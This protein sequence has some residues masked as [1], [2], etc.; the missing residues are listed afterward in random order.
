MLDYDDKLKKF[1]VEYTI[2]ESSPT[3]STAA[4]TAV[5]KQSGRLNLSFCDFDTDEKLQRRFKIAQNRRKTALL[6][7][8]EERII[9]NELVHIY[10]DLAMPSKIKMG[11]SRRVQTTID[12][13]KYP[14]PKYLQLLI[15]QAEALYV[16]ETLRSVLYSQSSDPIIRKL[17]DKHQLRS[18]KALDADR[19]GTI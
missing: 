5:I 16:Y 14:K 19:E 7:L 12:F 13:A 15:M 2:P 3:R 1:I 4:S 8:A 17:L 18:T 9:N 6:Q 11:I 10:R